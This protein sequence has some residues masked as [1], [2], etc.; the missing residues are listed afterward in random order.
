MNKSSKIF[1]TGHRGMV[2]SVTLDHFRNQGYSNLLTASHQ[3]LDLIN[4]AEVNEFMELHQ[5]E[6][7]IHIAAKVGGI[8]AN[9]LNPGVFLFDN[10]MMQNNLIDAA[11]KTGVKKFVFLGSSCIYPK[12][13]PQPMKEEYL[14]KGPLEPTNEGY[15]IAKIAG[16]KLLQSYH[17]QYNFNGISLMPSNLY[18]P[19]DSFDLAH[20]HV[21]SSLVKRFTDA[22]DEG[23]KEITLWG[24]G[25]ARREFLHVQDMAKAILFFFENYNS[26]EIVN[27]GPGTDISIKELA[28]LIANKVGYKGQILWDSSKPDGMLRKCMDVSNMKNLGYE[29]EISLETGIDEVIKSYKLNKNNQKVN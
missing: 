12:E 10:L 5:P 21:L 25:V 18:G 9:I 19:N 29:T 27:I 13:S 8:N 14:L 6:Y 20:A 7:V 17:K 3:E 16:I 22:Q 15:A 11:Q 23:L 28:E 24:T 1:I 2:G 26:P 4:Q